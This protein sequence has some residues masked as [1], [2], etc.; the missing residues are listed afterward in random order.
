MHWWQFALLG[1]GGGALVEILAVFKWFAVWQAARRTP[2]G[3]VSGR[4]PT[5]RT[6]IDLPA[7]AWMA[8]LRTVLGAGSATLFG[9]SGQINGAYVAVALG[10]AAPSILAQLGTIPQIAAAIAGTPE[11]GSSTEFGKAQSLG[12]YERDRT[13]AESRSGGN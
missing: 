2:T 12:R 10:F 3:R 5:L 9:A 4:P 7:H 8:V 1:A 13:A 11:V 6:Y